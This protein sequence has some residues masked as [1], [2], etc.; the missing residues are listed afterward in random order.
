MDLGR[1]SFRHL[2]NFLS[3]V[4]DGEI[5]AKSNSELTE[6]RN[7]FEINDDFEK[8]DR[9]LALLRPGATPEKI[10][11]A[12][13]PYFVGGLSLKIENGVTRLTSLFLFGQIFTPPDANGTAV[14]LGL[15]GCEKTRVYRGKLNPILKTLRLE[16]FFKLE[17]ASA[18][19][20]KPSDQTVFVLFD[21]RPH[22]WQV[23]ALENAFLTARDAFVRKQSVKTPSRSNVLNARGFFK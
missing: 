16:S 22:P 4:L 1:W 6:V 11:N 12:F 9:E 15:R 2:G 21:H 3:D 8:L 5:G 19:A 14:D 17:E 23:F 18:F 10:L 20:F 13:S 7:A